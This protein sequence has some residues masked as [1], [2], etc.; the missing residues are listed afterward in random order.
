MIFSPKIINLY[1][2][3][4]GIT[5]RREWAVDIIEPGSPTLG[6]SSWPVMN[7]ATQQEVSRWGANKASSVFT[8]TP[9]AHI[10][11]WALPPVRSPDSHRSTELYRELPTW[12]I[13]AACSIL[14]HKTGPSCQKG[15]GPP[16]KNKGGLPIRT[17]IAKL[18]CS[19]NGSDS[20]RCSCKV[21]SPSQIQFSFTSQRHNPGRVTHKR[22]CYWAHFGQGMWNLNCIC[23]SNIGLGGKRHIGEPCCAKFSSRIKATRIPNKFTRYSE[24]QLISHTHW[25]WI[26]GHLYAL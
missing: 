3:L 8:A 6:T 25:I 18:L 23:V 24:F 1:F 2:H 16:L 22:K 13:Y 5:E 7:W 14:P 10:T 9:R 17:W 19:S 21:S 12:G 4:E 20:T 26:P 11:A 15:W